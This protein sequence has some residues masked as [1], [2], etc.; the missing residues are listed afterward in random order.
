MVRSMRGT[1]SRTLLAA[2]ALA[3]GCVAK[4]EATRSGGTACERVEDCNAG[5]LCG[6]VS[7]CVQGYCAEETVFRACVDGGYPDAGSTT[8][9]ITYVSCNSAAYRP[10]SACVD[11]RCDETAPRVDVPCDAGVD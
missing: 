2:L 5:P 7:L 11:G 8:E 3:C 6:E 9:C 1:I 4:P 10:L